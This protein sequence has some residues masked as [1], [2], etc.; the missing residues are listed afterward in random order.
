MPVIDDR[1]K[2][3]GELDGEILWETTL[4]PKKRTLTQFTVDSIDMELNKIKVLHGDKPELRKEF[5]LEN[6]YRF[7][8]DILDN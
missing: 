4:N 2:G 3:L 8:R 6:E 7:N 1:I 5:M